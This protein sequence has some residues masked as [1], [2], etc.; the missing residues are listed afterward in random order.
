MTDLE[1]HGKE[2][3]PNKRVIDIDLHIDGKGNSSPCK[4]SERF[5]D[6]P[7]YFYKGDHAAKRE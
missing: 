5:L 2:G 1:G 6:S 7:A 3:G 4:M